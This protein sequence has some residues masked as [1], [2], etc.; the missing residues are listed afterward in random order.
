MCRITETEQVTGSQNH[1]VFIISYKKKILQFKIEIGAESSKF[2]SEVIRSKESKSISNISL[3]VY[4]LFQLFP[5]TSSNNPQFTWLDKY[6]GTMNQTNKG[7]DTMEQVNS[8]LCPFLI[9]LITL[10][11]QSSDIPITKHRIQGQ[12][13]NRDSMLRYQLKLKEPEYT[14]KQEFT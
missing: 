2:A 5:V 9:F 13:Y 12:T 4:L 14:Q 8:A 7:F 1:L 11:P 10:F 6:I 3:A